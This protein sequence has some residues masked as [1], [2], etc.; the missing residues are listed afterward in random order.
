M[1]V[2]WRRHHLPIFDIALWCG[3]GLAAFWVVSLLVE[4]RPM[5]ANLPAEAEG[6]PLAVDLPAG[7]A[8]LGRGVIGDNAKR[9]YPQTLSLYTAPDGS[10]IVGTDFTGLGT[11]LCVATQG[12]RFMLETTGR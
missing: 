4:R 3:L 9:A 12:V 10:W 11:H 1:R 2:W 6:C 7:Y 5:D 8:L